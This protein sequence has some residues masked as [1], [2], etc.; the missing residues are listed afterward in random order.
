MKTCLG[1][2]FGSTRIKANTFDNKNTVGIC[3]FVGFELT[4]DGFKTIIP[5]CSVV[6]FSFR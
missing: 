4:E 1:I 6:K 3:S 5:P 2:E